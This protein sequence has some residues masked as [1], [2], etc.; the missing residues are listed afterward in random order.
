MPSKRSISLRLL[1]FGLTAAMASAC[2]AAAPSTVEPLPSPPPFSG[3][4]SPTALDLVTFSGTWPATQRVLDDALTQLNRRCL[5]EQG[6]D[7]PVEPSAPPP[8]VDDEA[9]I[10]LPGRRSNG[11]GLTASGVPPA[12]QTTATDSYIDNLPPERQ[13]RFR[14][15]LFGPPDTERVVD[16]PDGSRIT[17]PGRGCEAQ[18]RTRLAGDVTRWA[19]LTYVPEYFYNRMA[20][21]LSAV[22]GF[23]D[24]LTAWRSCMTAKGFEY[25]SPD[26]AWQT[27]KSE[28]AIGTADFRQREIATAVADGECAAE[29]RLPAATL[30]ARRELATIMPPADRQML[31]ELAHY[32]DAIVERAE[33]A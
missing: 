20:A 15:A 33:S 18:S 30:A 11:Y 5:A 25:Q 32:R 31:H 10:D 4:L 23:Q 1:L 26:H 19:Q 13:Y 9:T 21:Q 14:T 24:A 7:Y 2:T 12:Q 8:A 27:F 29:T 28:K 22:P 17:V 6:F 16:L 3:T